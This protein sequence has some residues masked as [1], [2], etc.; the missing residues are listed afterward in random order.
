MCVRVC[1]CVCVCVCVRV[2]VCVCVCVLT[3]FPR[4]DDGFEYHGGEGK[5]DFR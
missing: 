4:V 1:V 5:D 2:C 3:L